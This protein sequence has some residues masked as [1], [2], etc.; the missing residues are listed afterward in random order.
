[1]AC[2][3]NLIIYEIMQQEINILIQNSEK[4]KKVNKKIE[5]IK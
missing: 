1:M 5:F 2:L 4:R 3:T